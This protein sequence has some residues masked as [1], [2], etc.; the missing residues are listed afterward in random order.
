LVIQTNMP[1]TAPVTICISHWLMKEKDLPSRY[2]T[3]EVIHETSK[4]VL[5]EGSVEVGLRANCMRCGLEITHPVSRYVGYGPT[6]CGH[7]GISRPAQI[8]ADMIQAVS[9]RIKEFT[10][11]KVWIPKSQI[12]ELR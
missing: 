8:T 9:A 3:G 1:T 7:L 6:C 10:K 11:M 12:E 5:F 4:A 2:L